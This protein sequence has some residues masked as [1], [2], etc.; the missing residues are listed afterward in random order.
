M[1]EKKGLISVIAE[2]E[3]GAGELVI[4]MSPECLQKLGSKPGDRLLWRVGEDGKVIVKK[5]NDR[6]KTTEKTP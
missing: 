1:T 6:T 5:P 3:N 4:E 2:A